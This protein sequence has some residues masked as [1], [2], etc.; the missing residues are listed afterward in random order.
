MEAIMK[1]KKAYIAKLEN[2]LKRLEAEI[3]MWKAK[4]DET[5]AVAKQ[6]YYQQIESLLAK[7][8]ALKSRLAA[9]KSS[10]NDTW[11]EVKE[12]VEKNWQ[13]LTKSFENAIRRF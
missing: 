3:D 5:A 11:D 12:R 7:K 8:E 2:R 6:E 4:T 1:G 9:L 10:T 13:D